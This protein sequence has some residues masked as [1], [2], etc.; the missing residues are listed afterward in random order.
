[1]TGRLAVP[2]VASGGCQKTLNQSLPAGPK[3]AKG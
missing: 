2:A 3:V 1:V